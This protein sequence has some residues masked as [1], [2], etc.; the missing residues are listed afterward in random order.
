MVTTT[1]GVG[2]NPLPL[3]GSNQTPGAS[4]HPDRDNVT[5]K[6]LISAGGQT[7]DRRRTALLHGTV[8]HEPV[9][10]PFRVP[11]AELLEHPVPDLAGGHTVV[12]DPLDRLPDLPGLLRR[13]TRF[14]RTHGDLLPHKRFSP[15][16]EF[17]NIDQFTHLPV[18]WHRTNPGIIMLPVHTAGLT[19]GVPQRE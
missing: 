8:V 1:T 5:Q 12:G 4:N 3:G 17:D 6:W 16:I 11:V 18:T 19:S 10:L 7:R 13:R 15:A 2:E 14:H 9:L